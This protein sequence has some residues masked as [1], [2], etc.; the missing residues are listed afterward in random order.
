M[1]KFR[2]IN[3]LPIFLMF[4]VFY[5]CENPGSENLTPINSNGN[6]S[7]TN[8]STTSP[9]ETPTTTPTDNPSTT[10]TTS[11]NTP[12]TPITTPADEN[13][14]TSGTE[15]KYEWIQ[16]KKE[17]SFYQQ[18]T[19]FT[20]NSS[21]I[22]DYDYSYFNST[23]DYS[24]VQTSN[25]NQTTNQNGNITTV[26]FQ[27]KMNTI[28]SNSTE[29][30]TDNSSSY[31]LKNNN[32]LKQSESLTEVDNESGFSKRLN[33]KTYDLDTQALISQSTTEYS[34]NLIND[35]GETKKYK[36]ILTDNPTSYSINEIKNG[37][38]Q[39]QQ[40][41]DLSGNLTAEIIF[42][43]PNNNPIKERVPDFMIANQKAFN[44]GNLLY[45]YSQTINNVTYDEN[46]LK[47]DVETRYEY[48]EGTTTTLID[49]YTYKKFQI[50][51]SK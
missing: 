49:K 19:D 45:E 11:P 1:K 5:G 42:S 38:C 24:R 9:T 17:L 10:P 48:P 50:P 33:S 46:E 43:E 16:T 39:K 32:W 35:D 34:I 29:T 14:N 27:Y 3:I 47:F 30:R 6:T 20:S 2:I 40:F 18:S 12:N 44:N 21:T 4:L 51:F 23:Y 15:N 41:Y 7:T 25:Q 13:T 37:I 36:Q 22:T 28:Y 31:T 26:E 8:N